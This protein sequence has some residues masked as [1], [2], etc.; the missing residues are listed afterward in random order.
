MHGSSSSYVKPCPTSTHKFKTMY[1]MPK[2]NVTCKHE[3]KRPDVA[4]AAVASA[5]GN[6]S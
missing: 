1:Q 5:E 3:Y 6:Y 2:Q 4:T